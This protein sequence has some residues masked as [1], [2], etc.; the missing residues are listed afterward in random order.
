M[1]LGTPEQV[2][3]P[4]EYCDTKPVARGSGVG[5]GVGETVGVPTEPIGAKV[6]VP[7]EPIVLSKSSSENGSS[8]LLFS[9]CESFLVSDASSG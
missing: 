4:Y 7:T 5:T 6:G 3:V 9:W 1:E 2:E 8:G